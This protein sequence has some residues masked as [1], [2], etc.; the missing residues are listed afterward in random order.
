M[1]ARRAETGRRGELERRRGGT[2]QVGMPMCVVPTISQFLAPPHKPKFREIWLA[3][4]VD[5]DEKVLAG[6][7]LHVV[8]FLFLF[9]LQY[10][11]L[12]QVL[13]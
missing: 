7:R 10:R 9:M 6:V 4:G 8:A 2:F 13:G 3:H 12:A 1:L 11:M 5:I